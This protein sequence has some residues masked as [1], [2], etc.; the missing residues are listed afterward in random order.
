MLMKIDKIFN[1]IPSWA[2]NLVTGGTK[3]SSLCARL[4]LYNRY[5]SKTNVIVNTLMWIIDGV[6]SGHCKQSAK[7]WVMAHKRYD[8]YFP[9]RYK[10]WL[11][12]YNL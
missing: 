4:Y 5:I 6:E 1:K 8:C 2:I 7:Y 12:I 3:H 9:S 10:Q 11:I